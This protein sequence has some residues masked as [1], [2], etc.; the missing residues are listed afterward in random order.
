MKKFDYEKNKQTK[1][2]NKIKLQ[3]EIDNI[4]DF[5]IRKRL[6][7]IPEFL[8]TFFYKAM[9]NEN[10]KTIAIKAKCLDCSCYQKK[11]VTLCPSIYCPLYKFRPYQ[12]PDETEAD[13]IGEDT[14]QAIDDQNAAECL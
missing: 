9:K 3:E 13:E 12:K 11:E 7:Q 1:I 4:S 14:E 5:G 8:K 10:S 2:E 6:N